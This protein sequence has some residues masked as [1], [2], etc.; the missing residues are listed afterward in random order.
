LSSLFA[1]V[2]GSSQKVPRPFFPFPWFIFISTKHKGICHL[3]VKT[4]ADSKIVKTSAD[5]N[6]WHIQSAFWTRLF[7]N[8]TNIF[9]QLF[10]LKVIHAAF[11]ALYFFGT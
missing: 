7:A 2:S 3:I 5:Q 10:C 1:I 9:E 6:N 8:F 11:L 4:S